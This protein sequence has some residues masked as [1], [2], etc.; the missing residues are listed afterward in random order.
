MLLQMLKSDWLRYSITIDEYIASIVEQREKAE[1][2]EKKNY[3]YSSFF[4]IILK[5]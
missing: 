4:E 3:A 1:F 2:F 5:K